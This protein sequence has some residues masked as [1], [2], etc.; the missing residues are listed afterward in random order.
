MFKT[1]LIQKCSNFN[2]DDQFIEINCL[3]KKKQIIFNDLIFAFKF[4]HYKGDL[5]EVSLPVG[6]MKLE[7]IKDI[8]VSISFEIYMFAAGSG[9]TPML[10]LILFFLFSTNLHQIRKVHLFYFNQNREKMV[11]YDE[12][13]YLQDSYS[14]W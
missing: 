5:V 10:R 4:V 13:K 1:G 3:M 9:I 8:I 2:Y 12:F 7:L 14:D 6:S 11:L